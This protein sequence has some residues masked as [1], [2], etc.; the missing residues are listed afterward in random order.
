MKTMKDLL[1]E[2]KQEGIEENSFGNSREKSHGNGILYVI[3]KIKEFCK[4]NNIKLDL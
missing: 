3:K 2:L 1:A 4:Q